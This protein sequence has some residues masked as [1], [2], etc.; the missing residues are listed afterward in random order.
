MGKRMKLFVIIAGGCWM[1]GEGARMV[2]MALFHQ[3]WYYQPN[4]FDLF[5]D[6]VPLTILGSLIF[7]EG[8]RSFYVDLKAE[9]SRSKEIAV[10]TVKKE[11][12]NRLRAT[13][14]PK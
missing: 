13:K 14:S 8:V 1:L 7:Y 12:G 6:W 9:Q 5:F 4:T 3:G 10:V 11:H 2:I